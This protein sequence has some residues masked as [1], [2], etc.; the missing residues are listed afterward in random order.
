MCEHTYATLQR[1]AL[2]NSRLVSIAYFTHISSVLSR[3]FDPLRYS[4]TRLRHSQ[5]SPTGKGFVAHRGDRDRRAPRFPQQARSPGFDGEAGNR[6]ATPLDA[7]SIPS[8]ARYGRVGLFA[9][10]S[11]RGPNPNC[12]LPL[13]ELI[14]APP[15]QFRYGLPGSV[16]VWTC[17]LCVTWGSPSRIRHTS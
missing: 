2:G 17:L 9:P 10:G 12:Y 11:S 16:T 14:T 6:R 1:V 5:T 3:Q 4:P 7:T 13:P 8:A 15:R